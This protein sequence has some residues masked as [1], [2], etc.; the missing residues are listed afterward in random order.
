MF[1]DDFL[2]VRL[3]GKGG[4]AR[5]VH[6]IKRSTGQHYAMKVQS[7]AALVK[8]HGKNE[9]GLELEKTMIA[10]NRNPF[11]VDLQYAL[12]TDLCA[13]LVLGLIGGGDLSDLIYSAPKGRLT[14]QHSQVYTYEIAFAL[15]HLH[16]NGVVYRDLKPS[17]ILVDDNGHLK[18]TDMGLAAPLYV[19][20][21]SK[22]GRR[23]NNFPSN[24]SDSIAKNEPTE[25][26]SSN[27]TDEA[28][29]IA[30][31]MRE[32]LNS[33]MVESDDG[34]T[35]SVVEIERYV[36]VCLEGGGER[37]ARNEQVVTPG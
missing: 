23:D 32:G 8:F 15:N 13:I 1:V 5:V 21:Q 6:V 31:A 33:A 3:L 34:G 22:R 28:D 14:E 11:I 16:E 20:E 30:A 17:N 37:V 24:N 36:F 4:F 29:I 7:K 27:I 9:G 25:E 19:F 35:S 18:L 26:M 12:Q 10:N 2:Y